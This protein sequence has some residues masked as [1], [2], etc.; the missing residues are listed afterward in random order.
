MVADRSAIAGAASQYPSRPGNFREFLPATSPGTYSA[1]E[2]DRAWYGNGVCSWQQR[3]I[4][5]SPEP[6]EGEKDL[7]LCLLTSGTLASNAS[8]NNDPH[9]IATVNRSMRMLIAASTLL[10]TGLTTTALAALGG[11]ADSVRADAARLR[12]QPIATATVLYDR[13][14]MATA[15]GL[16]HEFVSRSGQVF[17][18]TWS[19]QMPPDLRQ[20]LGPYHA[21]F[22]QA[23]AAQT[24][25]GA[26]RHAA[27]VLPDLVV[28]AV[29][30]MRAFEGAAYVPSLVPVGFDL[31]E[32][33]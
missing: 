21:D 16:V 17:A 4:P 22:Q 7:G 1:D 28:H 6:S 25:P 2:H 23:V 9:M 10:L 18:V 26:H 33:R 11:T 32:L 19:G 5:A 24:G 12:S 14:D 13:H 20:I 15:A 30:R 31:A 29:A 8:G 3:A 27:V